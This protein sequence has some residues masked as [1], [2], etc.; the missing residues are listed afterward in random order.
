MVEV[1][2]KEE[3]VRTRIPRNAIDTALADG[4]R[5]VKGDS[6]DGLQHYGDT[7]LMEI[8]ASKAK[9][10]K[11][12]IRGS[13]ERLINLVNNGK[14]PVPPPNSSVAD[15]SFKGKKQKI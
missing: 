14:S 15:F 7:V 6:P 9:E 1:K 4:F 11:E 2:E 12:R 8:P 13:Y 3:F 10:R 5:P